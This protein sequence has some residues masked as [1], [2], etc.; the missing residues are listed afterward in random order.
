MVFPHK[1]VSYTIKDCHLSTADSPVGQL[2]E[3]FMKIERDALPLISL[4]YCTQGK[5]SLW[6]VIALKILCGILC[7][8][9]HKHAKGGQLIE[10]NPPAYTH[11][12]LLTKLLNTAAFCS[13]L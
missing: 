12:F 5:T 8:R 10:D 6:K 1:P 3:N 4:F 2:H 11:V 7:Y 13:V 9:R